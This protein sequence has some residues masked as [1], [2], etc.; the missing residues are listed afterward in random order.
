MAWIA[1]QQEPANA[2]ERILVVNAESGLKHIYPLLLRERIVASAPGLPEAPD[3]AELAATLQERCG[4]LTGTLGGLYPQGHGGW[5]EPY[6]CLSQ[7][8]PH[9]AGRERELWDI[10]TALNPLDAG[11]AAQ[12]TAPLVVVSGESGL[13]KTALA[14]EYVF[15]FGAAY[16]GGIFLL[17]AHEARPRV[18]RNMPRG[19]AERS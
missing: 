16:P 19:W 17:S 18:R 2:P 7:P 14:R 10:H 6:D 11:L 15:R 4:L 3:P 12:R 9:F 1:R 8:Q 13:G 5:L